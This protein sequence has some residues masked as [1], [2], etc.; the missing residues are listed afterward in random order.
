MTTPTAATKRMDAAK[1]AEVER[2]F[3]Q[4]EQDFARGDF[5]EVTIEDL[6]RC[7]AAGKWPWPEESFE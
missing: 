1:Q 2:E 5:I 4:A 3:R 6:D 7:I